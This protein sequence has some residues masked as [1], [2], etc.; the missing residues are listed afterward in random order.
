MDNARAKVTQLKI[1]GWGCERVND[2]HLSREEQQQH[3]NGEED[4]DYFCYLMIIIINIT[5]DHLVIR[6][7]TA[8][9]V[10]CP[11]CCSLANFRQTWGPPPSH[12]LGLSLYRHRPRYYVE[13]HHLRDVLLHGVA[14][15]GDGCWARLE[16]IVAFENIVSFH[17][18]DASSGSCDRSASSRC[19]GLCARS[20]PCP[21]HLVIEVLL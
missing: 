7:Q 13:P 3:D 19:S 2:D 14:G 17:G 20:Y 1:Y 9:W 6:V 16:P 10:H 4:D 12:R 21:A 18:W 11:D 5:S 8:W 15:V